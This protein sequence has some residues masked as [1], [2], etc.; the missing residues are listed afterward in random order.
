MGTKQ[1]RMPA[2]LMMRYGSVWLVNDAV[3]MRILF[4]LVSSLVRI[5]FGLMSSQC[6]PAFGIH[7]LYA[8]IRKISYD[9]YKDV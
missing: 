9:V 2:E 3:R 7:V 6:C 1:H 8:K 5:L 4:G